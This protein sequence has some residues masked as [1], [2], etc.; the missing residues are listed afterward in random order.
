MAAEQ[1]LV[2]SLEERL[3]AGE[4][5]PYTVEDYL[6]LPEDGPRFQLMDGWLVREPAPGEVHQRVVGN[7]HVFL[8]Q[9]TAQHRLGRVY[10]AP[11]DVAL[12]PRDVVQP[13]LLFLRSEHL[14]RLTPKNLQGPPDLAVEV[15]SPTTRARDRLT[16]R[17]IYAA[18]RVPELWFIDPED[19]SLEIHHL[20]EPGQ[21]VA[22][23]QGEEHPRSKVLGLMT[24]TVEQL[25]ALDG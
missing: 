22:R 20:G 2:R 3:L 6:E 19:R 9:W 11:F 1:D 10:L 23:F 15:L 16:K 14:E 8:R 5:G 18:A 12:G 24:F 21:P 7:L 25:F 13:D 4:I 17:R